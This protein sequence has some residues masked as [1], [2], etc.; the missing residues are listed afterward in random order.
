MVGKVERE[1]W[2]G[3]DGVER[4]STKIVAEGIGPDLRFASATSNATR[5]QGPKDS[6][7]ATAL[8]GPDP[9]GSDFEEEPF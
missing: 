7:L 5:R 1:A 9:G 6:P 2:T 8:L 4:V 3:R